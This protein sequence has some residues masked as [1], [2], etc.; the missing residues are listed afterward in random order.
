MSHYAAEKYLRKRGEKSVDDA[1][2]KEREREGKQRKPYQ[3]THLLAQLLL[4][5]ASGLAL[6]ANPMPSI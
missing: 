4:A 1:I 3:F 5:K 6:K 2:I